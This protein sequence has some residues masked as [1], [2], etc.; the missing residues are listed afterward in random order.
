M[1]RIFKN[2]YV[3]LLF[4][5]LLQI[6]LACKQTEEIK[7]EPTDI[8]LLVL[9]DVEAP[10]EGS[11]VRMFD[12]KNKYE[13][14]KQSGLDANYVAKT[15]TDASGHAI[16][17]ELNTEKSYYF[18]VTYR[19]RVRFLDLDNQDESFVFNQYLSKGTKSKITIRLKP[20]KSIVGFYASEMTK[21]QL[22]ISFYIKNE[23]QGYDS[24]GRLTTSSAIP[25][26]PSQSGVLSFRLSQG[27]KEWYALS[28]SGCIWTGSIQVKGLESFEPISLS[29]CNAGSVS[30]YVDTE[31]QTQLPIKITLGKTNQI[32]QLNTSLSDDPKGC[33]AK[34]T[35]TV[36][37]E[38]GF[39]V[40]TAE[41]LR[42]SC[43]WTDTIQ[44]VKGGCLKVKLTK[45]N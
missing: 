15:I 26:S 22:P 24:I 11:V 43:V 2:N 17:K 32:G 3:V 45:C 28:E 16:F 36:A 18:L 19:N 4:L 13:E 9:D 25:N 44:I 7:F 5:G 1:N 29:D 39:Y 37:K 38:T 21:S 6:V 41:S 40:Y 30:F 34:G 42:N 31:N 12:D 10:V 8:D 27:V 23:S 20:A 33:F 35:L 14:A